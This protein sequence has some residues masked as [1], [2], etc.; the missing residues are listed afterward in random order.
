MRPRLLIFIIF[1]LA[2]TAP[3]FPQT[4]T[5]VSGTVIDTNGLP[6]SFARVSAQLIPST[7]SPTI[8]VNG[9]PT[10]IGGQQNANADTNGTFSMN[11]FCNTAGGGCSVI[12]PSGT[13]WQI[14]VTTNGMLPPFGLGPQSCSATLAITGVSQSVSASFNT[15]PAETRAGSLTGIPGNGTVTTFSSGALSPLFTTSVATPTTTPALSYVLS[16]AAANTVFGNCTGSSAAPNYCALTNAMLPAGSSVSSVGLSLPPEYSVSGSPVTSAGTLTGAWAPEYPNTVLAG[17]TLN[18][19]GGI[20]DGWNQA[21]ASSA[22]TLPITL[23]P[24]TNHDWAFYLAQTNPGTSQGS[25]LAVSG[26]GS[27]VNVFTSGNVAALFQQSLSSAAPLTATGS[28]PNA[29]SWAGAL[30]FLTASG[31]PSVVQKRSSSGGLSSPLSL[32]FT[33]N[34]TIGNDILVA[35]I[36]VPPS[37]G[38]LTAKITD[39]QGN[40][41][42][43]VALSQNGTA[44]F[45]LG[46]LTANIPGATLDNITY[47]CLT[48]CGAIAS[49]DFTIAEVANLTTATGQPTF[50]PIANVLANASVQPIQVFSATT[51]GGD[52]SV[53]ATTPTTVTSLAV[54]MPASG[55]PCRAHFSYSLYVNTGTS[56]VGYS[57]WINDGSANMAGVNTGQSNASSG[58][59]TSASYGGYSTVTYANGANVTFTLITEGDHTYTVKAASQLAGNAP[60]SS[61]Q[62]AISTSN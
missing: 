48:N 24:S 11:L 17:P 1:F 13:T 41:Y 52:V 10:Q 44:E 28:L 49:G 18:S 38:T 36:G 32:A 42:T 45:V 22:T 20:F 57:F 40:L 8:I 27:W 6:Y 51:L 59:L 43:P 35:L 47:T 19:I 9:I 16:N 25:P 12:S 62:V 39:S 5:V 21:T 56:G 61:F 58:G 26:G 14:T 23:T 2:T 33:S 15:C 37:A 30:F 50:Q 54:T 46:W 7:A 55:C 60:N 4:P 53:A 34:T 29:T 3:V 31:T